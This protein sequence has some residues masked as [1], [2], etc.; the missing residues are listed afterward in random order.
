MLSRT[1]SA[2]SCFAAVAAAASLAQ[3]Q[4]FAPAGAS[5]EIVDS[6]LVVEQSQELVCNVTGFRGLVSGIGHHAVVDVSVPNTLLDGDFLCNSVGLNNSDWTLTP[7]SA[8]AVTVSGIYVNS[9][10]GTCGGTV[11][12]TYFAN[13]LVIPRQAIPGNIFGF[14]T[15][16]YVFGFVQL[17]SE[18]VTIE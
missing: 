3:A 7:I 9:L 14:P 11:I 13:V 5:F 8:S 10:M 1:V 6:E 17:G 16:C 4:T 18:D 12:G 2:I 15:S